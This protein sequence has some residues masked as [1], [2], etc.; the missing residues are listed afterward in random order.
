MAA[1]CKAPA[2][3]KR[4]YAKKLAPQLVKDY[5]KRKRY[6]P[7]QILDSATRA[8]LNIDYIC[9]GY[10][11]FLDQAAFDSLHQ[12][13]GE[14]CDYVEMHTEMGRQIVE[15]FQTS[16]GWFSTFDWSAFNPTNWNW[17]DFGDWFDFDT[18]DVGGPDL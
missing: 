16:G 15:A 10:V 18:P 8:G 14:A 6:E 17:P 11:I 7:Q 9:W 3:V 2:D 4:D 1:T 13:T 5:G 12:Q